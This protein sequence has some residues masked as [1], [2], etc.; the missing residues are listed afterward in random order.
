MEKEEILKN[1]TGVE[2]G[3]FKAKGV[4]FLIK[5]D[6]I[7]YVGQSTNIFARVTSHSRTKEFDSF[8][9][10]LKPKATSFELDQLETKY[11]GKFT[12]KYNKQLRGNEIYELLTNINDLGYNVKNQ[13]V[14]LEISII[15]DK[16]YITREELNEKLED[17]IV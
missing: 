1:K 17:D 16:L 5:D 6:E 14:N 8:T 3:E 10:E 4:Y 7:V 9:Y 12:P 15:N 11:I 13:K 2:D